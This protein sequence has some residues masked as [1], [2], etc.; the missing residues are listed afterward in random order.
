MSHNTS[1]THQDSQ[2]TS[3]GRR[4]FGIFIAVLVVIYALTNANSGKGGTVLAPGQGNSSNPVSQPAH[5]GKPTKSSNCVA[6]DGV[7]D[8]A[9]TPGAIFPDVTAAQVCVSGYSASVRNVPIAEKDD[10][11]AEYNIASHFTGQYEVDHLISLELGGSNDIANLWPELAD[12]HPGFHQKDV[13]EN[14]LH[15]QVCS[16]KMTLVKAQEL[17]ATDWHVV[18]NSMPVARAESLEPEPTE[19]PEGCG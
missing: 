10:V 8:K 4:L 3:L 7:Q 19:C 16:G 12:P 1:S 5:L 17:I 14:Y 15:S 9:C 13:V 18:Y 2:L 6:T 11:Y